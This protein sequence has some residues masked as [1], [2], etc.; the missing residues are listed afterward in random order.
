MQIV[1]AAA[2]WA[3]VAELRLKRRG[4]PLEFVLYPMIHVGDAAFFAEVDRRLTAVDLVVAEGVRGPSRVVDGLTSVYRAAA[5]DPRTGVVRQSH[6]PSR[7]PVVRPDV[8]GAEFDLHWRTIPL[9][10]RGTIWAGVGL[11][12]VLHRVAGPQW[13][14]DQLELLAMDDLASDE[15]ILFSGY[16]GVERVV[17][18]ERDARLLAALDTIHTQRSHEKLTVAVVYGAAHM[19]AVVRGLGDRHGYRVY[20]AEWLTALDA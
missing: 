6:A 19:R 15:E 5:R 8:T 4:T 11:A 14:L 18:Q 12:N 7:V 10:E 3:R 16:E 2:G 1:E 17:L 13:W 9:W 20:T